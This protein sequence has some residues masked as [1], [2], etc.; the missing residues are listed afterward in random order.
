MRLN[1]NTNPVDQSLVIFPS[2]SKLDRLEEEEKR[3]GKRE[4]EV[5]ALTLECR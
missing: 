4:G 3:G 5:A 2:T 1:E